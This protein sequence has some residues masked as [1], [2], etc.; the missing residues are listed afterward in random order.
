M[1]RDGVFIRGFAAPF[2]ALGDTEVGLEEFAPYA[3]VISPGQRIDIRPGH[4]GKPFASTADGSLQL[5]Q[6]EFGLT[7]QAAMPERGAIWGWVDA[8]R[9]GELG[10][11]VNMV[12]LRPRDR[13]AVAR[14]GRQVSRIVH[15]EIDHVALLHKPC[16]PDTS[17]WLSCWDEADMPSRLRAEA[18]RWWAEG[19]QPLIATN[20]SGPQESFGLTAE[21]I[22]SLALPL[23][24]AAGYELRRRRSQ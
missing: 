14:D 12:G 20:S 16:Y 5:G 13:V 21:S 15:A 11:S 1:S 8:M 10:A 22:C 9:S 3:F 2:G 24:D 23:I 4:E 18:D 19:R 17:A 7:Y 6:N